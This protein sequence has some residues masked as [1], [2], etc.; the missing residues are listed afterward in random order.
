LFYLV[1]IGR[2]LISYGGES[3]TELTSRPFLFFQQSDLYEEYGGELRE[4]TGSV[5][6]IK[7]LKLEATELGEWV[8]QLKGETGVAFFDGSL[9]LWYLGPKP[10]TIV[11]LN[12]TDLKRQTLSSFLSLFDTAGKVG[13]PVVGYISAPR[14]TDLVNSLKV[15]LCSLEQVDC[16]KCPFP[17]DQTKLCTEIEGLNDAHLFAQIL[18][19]GERSILFESSSKILE[20]YGSHKIYFFYLHAGAEIVRVEVPKTLCPNIAEINL[21][22]AIVYDQ[23]VKGLGYPVVLTEAHEQAVVRGGDRE[24]LFTLLRREAAANHLSLAQSPKSISKRKR[25]V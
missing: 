6:A 16:D 7:R 14:S 3:T 11:S 4:V 17:S 8:K 15:S 2:A 22:Q 12:P 9:I 25:F 21:M 5:L 24:A 10:E 13:F 18:K 19:P 1:N 23:S 20:V